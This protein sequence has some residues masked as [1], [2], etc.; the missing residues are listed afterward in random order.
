MNCFMRYVTRRKE[1]K[2]DKKLLRELQLKEMDIIHEVQRICEKNQIEWMMAYGSVLGAMRHEGFIPWDDD[3]DIYMKKEEYFKF[4]KACEQDLNTEKFFLQT[5]DTDKNYPCPWAKI[6]M[7]DTCSMDGAYRDKKMHWGVCIDIFTMQYAPKEEEDRK[8][9]ERLHWIYSGICGLT[10][11]EAPSVKKLKEYAKY[12]FRKVLRISP[13][14]KMIERKMQSYCKD[15]DKNIMWDDCECK[16]VPAKYFEK[17]VSK[18]FE[19]EYVPCP[20]YTEEYLELI[21]GEWRAFPPEDKRYGHQG[22]IV[23]LNK[24]YKE[25]M[26]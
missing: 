19:N 23:D 16:Y 7:N 24:S 12:V 5:V 18:K 21:Y 4:V 10:F 3:I 25:Y 26:K 9:L 8:K 1:K 11:E 20:D 17:A 15:V 22:I 2:M 13:F 14:R 6:R